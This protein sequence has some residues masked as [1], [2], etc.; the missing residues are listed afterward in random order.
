MH[1]KNGRPAKVGDP[2]VGTTFNY[3]APGCTIAG[4]LVSC[5][6]GPDA[7]SAKVGMLVTV[8]ESEHKTD[9]SLLLLGDRRIYGATP[10]IVQGTEQHG[11]AGPK[12]A[13]YYVEDYT[14]CKHL[15]HAEDAAQAKDLADEINRRD[16]GEAEPKQAFKELFESFYVIG[17]RLGVPRPENCGQP[18]DTIS[19]IH[20]QL[21][22]LISAARPVESFAAGLQA[23]S[24]TSN[25]RLDALAQAS[26]IEGGRKDTQTLLTNAKAILAFLDTGQPPVDNAHVA[27]GCEQFKAGCS[28]K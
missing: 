23:I 4:T 26:N 9:G 18:V 17:D 27:E 16:L 7:C 8:L 3:T 28:E 12:A 13:T 21:D 6:P 5:T 2:V 24:C 22:S 14:E 11:S 25:T 20:H 10:I 15:L 1:Y 19:E